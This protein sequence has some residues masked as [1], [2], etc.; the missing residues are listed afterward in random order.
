MFFQVLG[1][2][3]IQRCEDERGKATPESSKC[4]GW[5]FINDVVMEMILCSYRQ[6]ARIEGAAKLFENEH[7]CL[8]DKEFSTLASPL[9]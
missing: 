3:T 7:T 1:I 8:M 6:Q 5:V 2:L 4:P 9:L